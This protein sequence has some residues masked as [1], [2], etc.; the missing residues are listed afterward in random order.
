MDTIE[1]RF[2]KSD[3]IVFQYT[4]IQ[5]PL[6][7]PESIKNPTFIRKIV[8][9]FAS[10][11]VTWNQISKE[12]HTLGADSINRP[13]AILSTCMVEYPDFVVA[14]GVSG[15]IKIIS[16]ISKKYHEKLRP[17]PYAY[18]LATD[19]FAKEMVA[20]R[21]F[22]EYENACNLEGVSV[23]KKMIDFWPI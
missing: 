17:K 8:H 6:D 11:N 5:C 13:Y 21:D 18:L 2:H 9:I 14:L 10:K 1:K 3:S 16:S 23:I 22:Y 15:A 7:T 12:I 20:W 19:N 4:V